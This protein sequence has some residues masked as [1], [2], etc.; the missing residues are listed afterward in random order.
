MARHWS[1]GI[2]TYRR[3]FLVFVSL[4]EVAADGDLLGFNANAD[5]FYKAVKFS[6]EMNKWAAGFS[7]LSALLMGIKL[8]IP[9]VVKG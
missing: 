5:Q 7:G 2:R 4:W 9:T 6:A 3:D 8:F 1:G